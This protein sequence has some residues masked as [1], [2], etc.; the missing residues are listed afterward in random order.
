[1]IAIVGDGLTRDRRSARKGI[2]GLSGSEPLNLPAAAAGVKRQRRA[3]PEKQQQ[4]HAR[5]GWPDGIAVAQLQ[6]A[7]PT[8]KLKAVLAFPPG[9]CI[10]ELTKGFLRFYITYASW[11]AGID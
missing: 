10:L 11:F 4:R 3:E 9:K 6:I 7:R 2:S 8:G 1:M 5:D